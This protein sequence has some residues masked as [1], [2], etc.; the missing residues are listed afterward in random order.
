[1][2]DSVRRRPTIAAVVMPLLLSSA[3][4]IGPRYVRPEAPSVPAF[5]ET[6]PAGW[7]DAEPSDAAPRGEWWRVYRET[8]L[9]ALEAQVNIS[10]QNVLA[11]EARYRMAQAAVRVTRAG[12]FP[13]VSTDVSVARTG[14][15]DTRGQPH[16][17]IPVDVTYQAD[18]WGSIR[19]SVAANT[20]LAQASAAQLEVA[21]LSYQAE[22]AADYFQ[23]QGIDADRRL[24]SDA[25]QSYEQ[26]VQLTQDRFDG[27]VASQ[28]DVAQ[29]R[30]QLETARAQLTEVG[31]VRAQFEH[32]IAVLVGKAPSD[33]F[34]SETAGQAA[35]PPILVGLPSTLLERRPD[36]ASAE[37]Q[38]A[39]ANEQIG[40]ARTAYF[41][42]LTFGV[43]AGSQ[44]A[45]IAELL[46]LPT[47]VWSLGANLAATIFDGG[48]R[49]AEVRLSE[50][51]YDATVAEYRQTVLTGLQQVEDSVAA[52]RILADESDIA[53]RAVAAA[54][55]SLDISM[56]Q[57]RGGLANYLPVIT[58]QT[59]LL[60]SQRTAVDLLTRRMLA[61][62]DLTQALGGGWDASQLPTASDI[63]NSSQGVPRRRMR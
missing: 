63:A 45:A 24:L 1:M 27:G 54:Q 29:A 31:I 17:A 14:T 6:L 7:K 35:P 42:S 32:A 58:A 43:S 19:R 36:V 18:V 4:A 21:R 28:G 55:Q 23:L 60:Q 61:S 5:K 3:C 33:V 48:K 57:Y 12:R 20:A 59:S 50:A 40:I 25:V 39:A 2:S 44:A 51:A 15:G 10:N 13:V 53:T 9:D 22:L 41:P 52:L 8:A 11:A 16:Y 26:A 49:R 38:V 56:I 46:T 37:R 62:V 47:R 34:L 30:T